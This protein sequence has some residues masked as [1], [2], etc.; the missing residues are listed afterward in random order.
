MNDT[1]MAEK[2]RSALRLLGTV[3]ADDLSVL[4]TRFFVGLANFLPDL[5]V[6]SLLVRPL[7]L[8]LAGARVTFPSRIRRPLYI[9]QASGI[10]IGRW[11]FINQGCRIEGRKRVAIGDGAFIGP[12][13][14]FENVNHRSA[15]PES[16]PITVGKSS[17]SGPGPCR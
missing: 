14:L 10:E 11:T 8:R 12:F 17:W 13:C 4:R 7:L 6:F 15:G 16:L 2:G 9:H 1:T 5:D 3:V